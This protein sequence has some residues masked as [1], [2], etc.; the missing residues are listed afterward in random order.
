MD[1]MANKAL[2]DS[3]EAMQKQGEGVISNLEGGESVQPVIKG[4]DNHLLKNAT[5][6]FATPKQGS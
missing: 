6:G 4:L 1:I 5:A 2:K 3:T